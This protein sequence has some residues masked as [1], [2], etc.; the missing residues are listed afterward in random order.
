MPGLKQFSF[1]MNGLAKEVTKYRNRVED[2]TVR[3]TLE[4]LVELTPV[5]TGKARSNW[6]IGRGKPR[7]A[8]IKAHFPGKNLGRGEAANRNMAILRGALKIRFGRTRPI[9][10]SNNV[11]YLEFLND[12][13]SAQAPAGFIEMAIAEARRTVRRTKIFRRASRLSK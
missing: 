8:V 5:D 4:V 13:S 6:L 7:T 9:F 12:G 2:V 11:D 10:I 3:R 1:R